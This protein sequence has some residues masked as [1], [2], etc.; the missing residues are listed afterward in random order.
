MVRCHV[1]SENQAGSNR[2]IRE[3]ETSIT[4]NKKRKEEQ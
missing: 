2:L 4:N 3:R 1:M